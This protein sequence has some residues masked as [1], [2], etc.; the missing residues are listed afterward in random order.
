M[1]ATRIRKVRDR[2]QLDTLIDDYITQGYK[3]TEEGGRTVMLQKGGWGEPLWHLIWAAVTVWWTCGLGNLGYAIYAHA[4]G[5]KVLLKIEGGRDSR[6]PRDDDD[7]R[8]RSR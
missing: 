1:A 8:P 5:P 4:N 2:E 3:V 6:S 7:D